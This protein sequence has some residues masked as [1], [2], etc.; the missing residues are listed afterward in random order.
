V[1]VAVVMV[2]GFIAS[3]KVALT[4]VLMTTPVAP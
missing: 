1:K 3:L 2:S 4:V